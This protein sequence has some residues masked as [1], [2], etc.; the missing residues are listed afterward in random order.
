MGRAFAFAP[1]VNELSRDIALDFQSL[2]D[3]PP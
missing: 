1:G 2:G 3:G